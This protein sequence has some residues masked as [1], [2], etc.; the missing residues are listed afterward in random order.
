VASDG[1]A[2]STVPT[3]TRESPAQSQRASRLRGGGRPIVETIARRLNDRA[4]LPLAAAGAEVVDSVQPSLYKCV[5]LWQPLDM[6]SVATFVVGTAATQHEY[7]A[8]V[9]ASSAWHGFCC[10]P[11]WRTVF[12]RRSTSYAALA[13]R[14]ARPVESVPVMSMRAVATTSRLIPAFRWPCPQRRASM[15]VGLTARCEEA[16]PVVE[17]RVVRAATRGRGNEHKPA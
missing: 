3:E 16:V 9:A 4:P 17:P 6:D 2:A 1:L 8:T 13:S 7:E 14:A 10:L 11:V 5:Q 15:R 12:C